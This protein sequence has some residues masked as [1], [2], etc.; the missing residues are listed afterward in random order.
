MPTSVPNPSSN[1]AFEARPLTSATG[2]YVRVAWHNG[3]REHIPGFGSKEEAQRWVEEKAT[4]WLSAQHGQRPGS[5][6]ELRAHTLFRA[7]C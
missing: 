4:M 6:G 1:P 2:W 5:L 7:G 3:K